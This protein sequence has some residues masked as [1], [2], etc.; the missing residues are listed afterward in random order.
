M[1]KKVI[2]E[3]LDKMIE[4]MSQNKKEQTREEMRRNIR[5]ASNRK[6][7]RRQMELLTEHSRVDYQDSCP[8]PE[9]SQAIASLHREL[10]KAD[11]ILFVRI[12]VAFLGFSHLIKRIPIKGIQFIKG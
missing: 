12:L 1:K 10:I 5:K 6:I 4:L 8:M 9:A 2:V 11:G 7:L 3:K